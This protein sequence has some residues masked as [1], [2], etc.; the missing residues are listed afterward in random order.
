MAKPSAGANKVLVASLYICPVVFDD[1]RNGEGVRK[2]TANRK[3]PPGSEGNEAIHEER[4]R[5]PNLLAKLQWS[6]LSPSSELES[7]PMLQ[8][9]LE[10]SIVSC[11][12][13][14]GNGL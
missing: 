2:A 13:G 1:D 3:R 6:S 14:I 4:S 10:L 12:S 7:D 5:S 11:E 9:S 8:P